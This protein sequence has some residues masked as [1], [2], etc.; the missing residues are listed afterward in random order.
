MIITPIRLRKNEH[1]LT[2]KQKAFIKHYTQGLSPKEAAIQAGYNP[3]D[4]RKRANEILKKPEA[5]RHVGL[6]LKRLADSE[7]K[8]IATDLKVTLNILRDIRDHGTTP[9]KLE[10]LA[11]P[12]HALNAMDME[13][14][15]LSFYAP[16][17]SINVNVDIEMEKTQ[18]LNDLIKEKERGY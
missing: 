3:R 16:E 8:E 14:K 5:K 17:K 13:A 6:G 2:D 7:H 10:K 4:A 1:P 9:E 11:T 12:A 15:I 18:R